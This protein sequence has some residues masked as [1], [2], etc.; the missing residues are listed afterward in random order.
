MSFHVIP[1]VPYVVE[2]YGIVRYYLSETNRI[3]DG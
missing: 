1:Y 3:N 2:G